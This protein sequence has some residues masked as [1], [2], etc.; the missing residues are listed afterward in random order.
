MPER[1]LLATEKGEKLNRFLV[2]FTKG[3][4]ACLGMKYVIMFL[5]WTTANKVDSL[6]YAELYY[7]IS[8]FARRFDL[9]LYQTTLDDIRI[10][11]D[12][13]FGLTKNGDL[14]VRARITGVVQA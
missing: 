1:W 2:S 4:R 11:R 7:T 5:L 13:G 9:E 10:V 3:S 12:L 8:R 6:A 14:K